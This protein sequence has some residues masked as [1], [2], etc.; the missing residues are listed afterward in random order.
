MDAADSLCIGMLLCG[1]L[2]TVILL[3]TVGLPQTGTAHLPLTDM[4]FIRASVWA[5]RRDGSSIT[6]EQIS[7]GGCWGVRAFTGSRGSTWRLTT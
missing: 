6:L 7:E 4:Q 2:A 1:L 5:L 3:L